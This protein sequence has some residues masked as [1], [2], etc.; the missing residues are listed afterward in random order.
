MTATLYGDSGVQ[1][2][3]KVNKQNVSWARFSYHLCTT[4]V[5]NF[6]HTYVG[7]VFLGGAQN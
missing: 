3:P 6:F 7:E 5:A 4:W 1:L 2:G